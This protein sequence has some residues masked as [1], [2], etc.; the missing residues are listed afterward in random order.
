M[1]DVRKDI[2]FLEEPFKY[3][4]AFRIKD[5]DSIKAT[6]AYDGEV[7]TLKCR[8]IDE[9]HCYIGNNA[10]HISELAEKIGKNGDKVEPI[11]GQKPMIDVIAAKYGEPLK[12]ETIH[13]TE[14]ALKK[15]VGGK[16]ETELLY[17]DGQGIN[18]R[19]GPQVHGTVLRGKDG[20]A[21]CG[22]GGENNTPTSLHPYWAQSYKREISTEKPVPE[23]PDLIGKI[24][25]FKAKAAAQETAAPNPR[26]SRDGLE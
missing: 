17:A 13:M 24:D 15:L 22:V 18:G 1:E 16:Y 10:Y 11:P 26:K 19:Y 4:E 6:F 25:K 21:V 7:K 9:V 23:K 12:D 5:G 3:P 14:A 20:I 8:H 2:L